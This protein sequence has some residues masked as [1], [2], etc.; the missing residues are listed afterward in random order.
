MSQ[1]IHIALVEPSDIVREGIILHLK[2][3][4]KPFII[5][6]Y[7]DFY[8][9]K[10]KVRIIDFQAV[11]INPTLLLNSNSEWKEFTKINIIR[12]ALVYQYIPH[13]IHNLF[14]HFFYIEQ[15]I[16]ELVKMLAETKHQFI[17]HENK[18]TLSSREKEI[19][20]YLS[21]G[22]SIKEIA[23]LVHLSPHTILTHRKNISL[24]T[25]IK[26][27]A[28]LTVYAISHGIINMDE[29]NL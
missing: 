14:D 12:I 20:R 6:A 3:I 25:G 8:A 10:Q 1:T 2:K 15:H 21:K 24:K 4:G 13:N 19:L 23:D 28:G 11:I 18:D 9:F 29:M 5:N 22:K 26:T 7:T 17:N 27:I 16:S